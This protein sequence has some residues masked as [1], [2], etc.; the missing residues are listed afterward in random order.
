[1]IRYAPASVLD[2]VIPCYRSNFIF[3]I[4]ALVPGTV[5]VVSR[6][7]RTNHTRTNTDRQEIERADDH[8][9]KCLVRVPYQQY[10]TIPA[11]YYAF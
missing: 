7:R 4:L 6:V 9:S 11:K 10:S 8:V 1:M 3:Y 2:V 5:V